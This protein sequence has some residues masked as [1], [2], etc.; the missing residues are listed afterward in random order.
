[1]RLS[2]F[3]NKDPLTCSLCGENYS[4]YK[5][6][7]IRLSLSPWEVCDE[8]DVPTG[9]FIVLCRKCAD[10]PLV[11][12]HPTLFCERYHHEGE[13]APGA[14]PQCAACPHRVALSCTHP[15][16]LTTGL[17]FQRTGKDWRFQWS[18][19][20]LGNGDA[21]WARCLARSG[22]AEVL[23]FAQPSQGP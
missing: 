6:E 23:P 16:K 15:L 14:M 1:M 7:S 12:D 19:P 4:K 13:V 20:R 22:V 17:K 11:E 21:D 8:H 9:E 18:D 3:V 10:S 2:I 5:H